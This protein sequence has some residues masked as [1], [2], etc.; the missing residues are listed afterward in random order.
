MAVVETGFGFQ[1]PGSTIAGSPLQPS[2]GFATA[3]FTSHQDTSTNHVGWLAP[4]ASAVI[5][6]TGQL[7]NNQDRGLVYLAAEVLLLNRYFSSRST[8]NRERDRFRELAFT[9]ARAPFAPTV[10]DTVFE[11]FEQ[12]GM[13][14]ESGPFDADPGPGFSPPL[15]ETT[16]NGQVWALARKTFFPDPD[17]PPDQESEEFLRA[18]EFYRDR[19]V[20]PNFLWSWQDADSDRDLF[21]RSIRESDAAFRRATQQIGLVL[22]NHLLSTVDAFVSQ[23]LSRRNRQADLTS[24]IWPSSVHGQGLSGGVTLTLSF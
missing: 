3:H 4:A 17:N 15:D 2:G 1:S 23:R 6:G 21:R 14:V 7:L 13:F 16:F 22:V 5:P 20:G 9:I 24:W 19:A 11:Y 12:V 18:L 10:R 8:G